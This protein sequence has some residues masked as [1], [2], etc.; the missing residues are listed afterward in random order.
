[1]EIQE[2]VSLGRKTT[3]RI[4]GTARYFVEISSKEDIEQAFQFSRDKK[5]PLIVLGSG[6]NT[7][8]ADGVISAV[9]MR[10]LAQ[11]VVQHE[12]VFTVEAGANLQ[13]LINKCAILGYDLSPL[14][15]IPGTLG[16]AIF[17]NAGQGPSGIWIDHYI[18]SVE[19]FVDGVWKIFSTQ[20]CRFSYRESIF[21]SLHSSSIW[22]AK[23][24]VPRGDPKGIQDTIEQLLKKR[25]E[26][27]PHIRTAG[28][29]FKAVGGV[30]AWQIIDKAN[31]RGLNVGGI[32]I[33]KKHANFLLNTG[34][35]TFQ[36]A[37]DIV[38][39]VK[40]TCGEDLEV[41]MRYIQNDGTL[42]F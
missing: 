4:G 26:T 37:V 18:E 25:I 6:S 3:M 16:G 5:I 42:Q 28:S 12:D 15:G 40:T 14:T 32:E 20:E 7:I 36:D 35:G 10:V 9:V 30:P 2:G 39:R 17:G 13:N 1:M 27:Q 8:F 22:S 23:L 29:C 34:S 24:R 11:D 19:A 31:L 38:K 21:K 41:E 33:S